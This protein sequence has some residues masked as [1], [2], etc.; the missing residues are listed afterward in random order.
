MRNLI[1]QGEKLQSL[2]TSESTYAEL[3]DLCRLDD[4]GCIL[5]TRDGQL[6]CMG[7][8]ET[9]RWSVDLNTV[10]SE[11][12]PQN[13]F[14]ATRH[15][16]DEIV[17]LA[18]NGAIVTVRTT[19]GA[20]QLV[21]EF[22]NGIHAA[23]WSP[24]GQVLVLVTSAA[25][26]SMSDNDDNNNNKP[27]AAASETKTT[28]L[29][30]MNSDFEVLAEVCMETHL[31]DAPVFVT[32]KQD[33]AL[34]AVSSVDAA[35]DAHHRKL[36]LYQRDSLL[37]HAL[38]RT[39]DGSGKLVPHVQ[40]SPLAWSH[41]LLACAQRIGSKLHVAF[42]E[43]NGLRHG[44]FWLRAATTSNIH[45]LEWNA[46]SD[47]LAVLLRDTA[48][49]GNK[50]QLWHRS[51]YHWYLK[52]EFHFATKVMAIKFHGDY[53]FSVL[54]DSRCWREYQVR[55]ESSLVD[56]NSCTAFV[57]D[58]CKLNATPLDH[59]LLPPPMYASYVELQHA[60]S[61]FVVSRR[62][63]H[64]GIA[65]LANGDL[66]LIG[67]CSTKNGRALELVAVPS[68]GTSSST[69][70]LR[71]FVI[72]QETQTTIRLIAV[73]SK[74][75]DSASESIVELLVYYENA[76]KVE[77]IGDI[78]LHGRVLTIIP[79]SDTTEGALIELESGELLEYVTQ[80]GGADASRIVMR[81]AAE[82]LLEPCPT[83][84]ALYHFSNNDHGHDSEQTRLVV[85]LSARF[86]LYCHDLMLADAV[87]SFVLSTSH[88]YVCF[89]TSGSRCQ[90]RFVSLVDLRNFDPLAG[91]DENHLL[92]GFEPRNIERG[93]QLVAI[94]PS[95]PTTI[96]QMPRGNL[97]GI[98]PRALVLRY[99]VQMIYSCNF[100]AAFETMR[101]QKI[102]LNLMIDLDPVNFLKGDRAQM[103]L[104]QVT[105]IDHLNLFISS[106]KN[107]D[108]T[109]ARFVI[110]KSLRP[111]AVEDIA[112]NEPFDF[113][114]KVNR[115]CQ[116]FRKI[117]MTAED[118]K[119]TE[120]GREI[121]EG[122]FLLPILSTFAKE[123]P[124]KLED[125]LILIKK[126]AMSQS[127][128]LS[129]KPPLFSESAQSAIQY[130]AFLADY[131]M[132][133]ESALSLY[134][135][136]IARAVAR[137]SQM[138]PKV[139]LPLLKRYR[140]LPHFYARV[141]VDLRLKRFETA[142]RNLHQS[143][144]QGE[145]LEQDVL[146][147]DGNDFQHCMKLIKEQHLHRLGLEL[148]LE[149]EQR[150]EILVSLGDYLVEQN[151]PSAALSVYMTS[152][153]L[154]KERAKSAARRCY[155]WRTFFACLAD[156][157]EGEGT[158]RVEL[159][160][161]EIA[162][163]LVADAQGNPAR[164]Q[165]LADAARILSDYGKDIPKSI[166]CL[167]KGELWSEGQR[168]AKLSGRDDLV[169]KCVA[170]ALEYAKQAISDFDERKEEFCAANLRY[171]IVL[172]IR[173]EAVANGEIEQMLQNDNDDTGSLF[174]SA[175][176]ASNLS[177][178]S[179]TS[180]GST[181][182]LSSVISAKPSTTFTLSG[183]D[184]HKHKSKYNVRGGKQKKVKKKKTG[185]TSKIRP[186]S[187]RELHDLVLT[188]RSS[189]VD[190]AYRDIVAETI[191]FLSRQGK[192][193]IARSLYDGLVSLTQSVVDSQSERIEN[194]R[195]EKLK[196][197]KIER[198]DGLAD[199]HCE[200][201]ILS[202]EKEV[203]TMHCATL[204]ESV[205]VLFSFL[206][207]SVFSS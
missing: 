175:S 191:L 33:S 142:L 162:D 67:T 196:K 23:A 105:T 53:V 190:A 151:Q 100:Q 87:S 54:L 152:D 90:L 68:W 78:P 62:S 107:T 29:L 195:V 81:S 112:Y 187:E 147:G 116:I 133:F 91:S 117:M 155:D 166:D 95:K 9:V 75:D 153:P 129:K 28:V 173:K 30:S 203:N 124:P 88:E 126:Y 10:V 178:A 170:M 141:E 207:A 172:K 104:D 193:I 136:D 49:A 79:W 98:Y 82:P 84:S 51:N 179:N 47:L 148:F 186:G 157:A 37:L 14:Q 27:A 146:H 80:I 13:W 21:G 8:D 156:E 56:M 18:R 69:D 163:E 159:E 36:R 31:P 57:I 128:P 22:E 103:F 164:R 120:T 168:L 43:P 26:V 122:H 32:W 194:A 12:A 101:R 137:D 118:N 55:W 35:S 71:N 17:C 5:L 123:D 7:D 77:K 38:G 34:V 138:D 198:R 97:E 201:V 149:P 115:I 143:G 180:A 25:A 171:A 108:S 140:E 46:A 205:H 40:D 130:L 41:S 154:D 189:C 70:A 206:P 182:S 192:T 109:Q 94:S 106:L 19:T 181:G 102:D 165:I 92:Q 204:P 20:I 63:I 202:V 150:S 64:A 185:K 39:E 11:A 2:P 45:G 58:G 61:E 169:A 15:G 113:S 24:D 158:T 50:V 60:V 119:A 66:V 4:D 6:T 200:E 48:T 197:E 73:A 111:V 89:A 135:F 99:A 134:D 114:T 44:Q 86:R 110:P 176:N 160:A 83:L 132:L 42:L 59:A 76:T 177:L 127:P 52:K 144:H 145:V 3:V 93:A 74:A 167:L 72:V 65:V 161:R 16:P 121:E 85:G 96:L 199:N 184:A 131:E 125:A 139:Y 188:L 183:E 174:S 1:L